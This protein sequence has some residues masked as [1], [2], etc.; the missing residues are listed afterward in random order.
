MPQENRQS[1]RIPMEEVVEVYL[2]PSALSG[3]SAK[4]PSEPLHLK[5]RNI[6]EAGLCLET[7][8]FFLPNQI[9]KLD[10][11]LP[12]NGNTRAYAE[13]VWS[14]RNSCGLRFIKPGGLLNGLME[15][16]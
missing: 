4:V 13:V 8:E 14:E 7:Q 11:A 9:F 2:L 16:E 15:K 10:F 5:A 1:Q 12:H 3:N 6:S